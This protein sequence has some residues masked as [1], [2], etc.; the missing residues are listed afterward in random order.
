MAYEERILTNLRVASGQNPDAHC[1]SRQAM[2]RSH[3]LHKF[4]NAFLFFAFSVAFC[5]LC[6]L[7]LKIS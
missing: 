6:S 5:F 4:I 3:F 2:L 7:F 1:N